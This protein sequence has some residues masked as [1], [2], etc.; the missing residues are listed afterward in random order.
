[1]EINTGKYDYYLI[2]DLEA[3]CCD[4]KSI[5]RREMETIEIGAVIVEA[6]SLAKV[7][8][9]SIFIKPVRHP[10]L[11]TFC[12]ELTSITQKDVDS[13]CSFPEAIDVFKQWLYVYENFIFCSWGDYDKSQIIQD[14]EYHKIP[15]PIGSEHINIK[16][17]FSASQGLKKKFGM[18]GALKAAKLGLDGTHHRGIDDAKNMARLMPY[19]LGLKRI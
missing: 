11:T 1:M 7:D 4:K 10:V 13:A 15:Y 17:L 5:P 12:T 19:I 9:L 2:V 16:K 14:C 3:S 6:K 18:A 8:E